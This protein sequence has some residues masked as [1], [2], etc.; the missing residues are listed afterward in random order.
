MTRWLR[1]LTPLVVVICAAGLFADDTNKN[2]TE[3]KTEDYYPLAAGTTWHYKIGE[4]KATVKV[5]EVSKEGV[6]KLETTVDGAKVADE[7]IAH[8]KEGIVRVSYNG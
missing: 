8:T 2:N 5:A 7:E 6:A 3:V 1:P 4:K